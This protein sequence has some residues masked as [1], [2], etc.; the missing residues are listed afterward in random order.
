MYQANGKWAFITGAARGI[1]YLA[2]KYMAGRGCNLILH[3]RNLAH[4]EKVLGEVKA[5]GVEACAVACD[6]NDLEAVK[7]CW[8]KQTGLSRLWILF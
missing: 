7:K 4:T 2:A 1:G 3:S 8:L 6:L 5:M